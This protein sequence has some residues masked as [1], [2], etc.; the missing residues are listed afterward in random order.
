[1]FSHTPFSASQLRTQWMAQLQAQVDLLQSFAGKALENTEKACAL[2]LNFGHDNIEKAR[3]LAQQMLAAKNPQDFLA[4]SAQLLKPDF[5]HLLQYGRNLAQ[6]SNLAHT[7]FWQQSGKPEATKQSAAK[8][9]LKQMA[10]SVAQADPHVDNKTNAATVATIASRPA[11]SAKTPAKKPAS[12]SSQQTAAKPV[13]KAEKPAKKA[14][15]AVKAKPVAAV[16]TEPTSSAVK[17]AKPE[18]K[19][20]AAKK[21]NFPAHM[22]EAPSLSVNSASSMSNTD[23]KKKPAAKNVPHEELKVATAKTPA[24]KSVAKPINATTALPESAAISVEQIKAT[25]AAAHA[26]PASATA[27][28]ASTS[29]ESASAE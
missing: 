26:V 24:T 28:T 6:L 1:M 7:P 20:S 19:S 15:Q 16:T 8:N 29:V 22:P 27:P 10:D 2:H 9:G 5:E 25:D 23:G 11:K 21:S 14:A 3:Q 18:N 4:N 12:K 17:Q 13:N